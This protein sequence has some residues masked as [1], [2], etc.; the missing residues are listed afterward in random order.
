MLESGKNIPTIDVF[1]R[2]CRAVESS[3]A[4]VITRLE[5]SKK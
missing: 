1:I 2:L 5:E 3:P 4:Q